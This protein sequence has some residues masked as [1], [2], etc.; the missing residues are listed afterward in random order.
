M[1]YSDVLLISHD[2]AGSGVLVYTNVFWQGTRESINF[3]CQK[4]PGNS[5]KLMRYKFTGK[6]TNLKLIRSKP[7]GVHNIIHIIIVYLC[8]EGGGDIRRAKVGFGNPENRPGV[9]PIVL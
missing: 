6:F 9:F 8:R 2:P 3:R 4:S 7:M 5:R 1:H